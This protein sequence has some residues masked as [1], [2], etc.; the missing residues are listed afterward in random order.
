MSGLVVIVGEIVYEQ[1]VNTIKMLFLFAVPLSDTIS[2]H[3]FY[4]F[5]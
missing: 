5:L 4:Y 2:F 3:F 1:H